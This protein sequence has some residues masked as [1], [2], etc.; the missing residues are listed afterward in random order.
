MINPHVTTTTNQAVTD[1]LRVWA[2]G[3]FRPECRRSRCAGAPGLRAVLLLTAAI[4][5]TPLAP[6]AAAEG[7]PEPAA[8]QPAEYTVKA[9]FLYGFGRFVQWPPTAFAGPADPFVIG[10]VGDDS[11]GGAW[12][13]SR[14]RGRF[15]I[16]AW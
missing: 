3:R 14:P 15:R 4:A 9:A 12:T 8:S 7:P 11:F 5:A 13:R 10:L 6:P 2:A 1:D 16:G